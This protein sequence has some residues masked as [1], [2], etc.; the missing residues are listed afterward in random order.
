MV[1]VPATHCALWA[2]MCCNACELAPTH[3]RPCA[4]AVPPTGATPSCLWAT[5]WLRA[6]DV[7]SMSPT[8]PS[9]RPPA[10]PC[11]ALADRHFNINDC[12][13]TTPE[14][15]VFFTPEWNERPH[16]MAWRKC[17]VE[18]RRLLHLAHWFADFAEGLTEAEYP[19][20]FAAFTRYAA[21]YY[22]SDGALLGIVRDGGVLN[23]CDTDVDMYAPQG[24]GKHLF[25]ALKHELSLTRPSFVGAVTIGGGEANR[26]AVTASA[27]PRHTS[28][29]GVVADSHMEVFFENRPPDWAAPSAQV[30]PMR[31]CWFY[32]RKMW[33]PGPAEKWLT[34]VFKAS[35]RKP[36]RSPLIR[37]MFGLHW[38]DGGPCCDGSDYRPVIVA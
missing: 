23:A 32:G 20:S 21:R 38:C 17:C 36:T 6:L 16:L 19:G 3:A 8:P 22:V 34:R 26:I 10:P 1:Y 28:G 24:S 11:L 4:L 14:C 30:E 25:Q 27:P 13:V 35:W 2:R 12:P 9:E 33:I 37:G 15:L 7:P 5:W 18:H 31:R 29:V